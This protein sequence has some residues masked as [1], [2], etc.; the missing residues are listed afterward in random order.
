MLNS[1]RSDPVLLSV[2]LYVATI[3]KELE[4]QDQYLIDE[5]YIYGAGNLSR[6]SIRNMW[7]LENTFD[8]DQHMGEGMIKGPDHVHSSRKY[9]YNL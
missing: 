4:N 9:E 8:L 5:E 3:K 6:K 7:K 2:L 1:A